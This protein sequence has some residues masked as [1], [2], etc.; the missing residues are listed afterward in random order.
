[1]KNKLTGIFAALILTSSM[2]FAVDPEERIDQQMININTASAEQMSQAMEGVGMAKAMAIVKF[3][4][5]NGL[6][7]NV[8]ELT[9]VKGIGDSTLEKN[10]A[11]LQELKQ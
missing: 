9:Q 2:A 6:F 8:E 4:E 10:R 5:E 11:I 7:N 3:R 1:M